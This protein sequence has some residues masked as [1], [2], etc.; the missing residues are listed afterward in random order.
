MEFF[1]TSRG[2][3]PKLEMTEQ[4]KEKA[5]YEAMAFVHELSFLGYNGTRL[6]GEALE[7]MNTVAKWAHE[8]HVRIFKR[9]P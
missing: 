3:Y 1:V 2:L 5:L 6:T 8:A 7:F 9:E 4:E